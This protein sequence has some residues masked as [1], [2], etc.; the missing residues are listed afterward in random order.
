MMKK[1]DWK[2]VKAPIL[3]DQMKQPRPKKEL[4]DVIEWDDTYHWIKR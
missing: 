3:E 2:M 1:K 4:Q